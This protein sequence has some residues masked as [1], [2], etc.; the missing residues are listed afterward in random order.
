MYSSKIFVTHLRILIENVMGTSKNSVLPNFIV[1]VV[2]VV[3]VE[4]QSF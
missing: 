4:K 3:V 2:V 1:V